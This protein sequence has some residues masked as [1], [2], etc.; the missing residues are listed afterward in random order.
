MPMVIQYLTPHHGV[1]L[2]RGNGGNAVVDGDTGD[3]GGGDACALREIV[4]ATQ[5]AHALNSQR[6]QTVVIHNLHLKGGGFAV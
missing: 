1:R 6:P 4:A 3:A 2:K 5:T